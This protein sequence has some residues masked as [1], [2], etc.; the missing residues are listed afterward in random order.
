MPRPSELTRGRANRAVKTPGGRLVIHR[1]K[2]YR[3]PGT[4]AI[5][6]KK[7]MLPREAK[8]GRSSRASRSSKRPNR[9]YGG[10]VSSK[11]VRRGII[12]QT[13]EE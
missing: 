8:H 7:M 6:G 2:F 4:C 13:R 11:A 12:K 5:T 3:T 1:Q 9:P 10:K